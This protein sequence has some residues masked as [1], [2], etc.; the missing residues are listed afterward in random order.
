[1]ER[2]WGMGE[3]GGGG[4]EREIGERGEGDRNFS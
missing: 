3:V 2:E 4:G 1:M